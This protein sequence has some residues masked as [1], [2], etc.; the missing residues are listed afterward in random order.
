MS[1][2]AAMSIRNS[3][4]RVIRPTS[5]QL[6]ATNTS[7]RSI[8]RC[9]R[10]AHGDRA[11]RISRNFD[12]Y[13][14]YLLYHRRKPEIRHDSNPTPNDTHSSWSRT[15]W[16]SQS[17]S[18]NLLGE[19]ESRLWDSD[20]GQMHERIEFLRK[21]IEADPYRAV[22]G[23]RF[24]PFEKF[25]KFDKN[26]TLLESF[27]QSLPSMKRSPNVRP[28]IDKR[29]TKSEDN[30]VGLQYDPISGHMVPIT[31]FIAPKFSN[32]EPEI[33]SHKVVNYPPGNEVKAKFA[34]SPSLAED[35][36]LQPENK[37]LT[38]QAH[39]ISQPTVDCPPGSELDGLFT[40]TS[41]SQDAQ[42]RA[43]APQETERRPYVNIDYSPGSE[44]ETLFVSESIPSVQPQPDTFNLSGNT[45]KPNLDAGLT[46]G[47]NV[48]CSPGSELEAK[49]ISDPAS[50]SAN[51]YL[52]GLETQTP[53]KQI[54]ISIDCSPGNELD[55]RL[56]SEL[57][58]LSLESSDPVH[59]TTTTTAMMGTQESVEC[60][61]GSEIQ[62]EIQA[63]ILS[64]SISQNSTQ[65][66]A[67]TSFD[68]PPGSELEAIFVCSPASIEEKQLQPEVPAS[69]DTFKIANS[70]VDCT[71]GNEL[72]VKLISEMASTK[73]PNYNEDPG[74][75]DNRDIRFCYTPLESKLQ[76]NPLDFDA[77]KGRI[78]DFIPQS[79]NL[80]TE[81]EEQQ[82]PSQKSSPKFHIFALDVST[83]QVTTAQA[84]SFFGI[85][86]DSRPSEILSRLHNPAKFL[87]YF[88]KMQ[89]GGYK[90]ATGGGNILVFRKSQSTHHHPLSN[91]ATDQQL[92]IQAKIAKHLRHDPM[93]TA[94]IYAGTPWQ[95]TTEPPSEPS[96]PSSE[97]EPT[98][99][100][101]SSVR[102]AGRRILI[103]GTATVVTCYTIGVMTEFFRTG[104]KDGRGID[105]FTVFESDRRRE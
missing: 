81:K 53:N 35:G 100:S 27:L 58:S 37:G 14:R 23:R 22:F 30:H 50:R 71:P 17:S 6:V 69:L 31:S 34:Y 46:V 43:Q 12:K 28:R 25:D 78:G 79:Q 92:A 7:E 13:R 11:D 103:A 49:F 18:S 59:L 51:S 72:E 56:S 64:E 73:G 77:S 67:Q 89:E 82:V 87:P 52:S 55:A 3:G 45:N 83:S 85:D 8:W 75:L 101:E 29:Q 21:Y 26:D 36:Q 97:P 10:N 24:D 42:G 40:S 99:N 4:P 104:G 93:E 32:A 57:T 2:L 48:E 44:L 39:L 62:S 33:N 65:S 15:A 63:Q 38:P 20:S 96:S 61:P 94:A 98:T 95:P 66:G 68:C 70:V 16:L 102:K 60:S 90:I 1:Y 41:K 105:G 84:D 80:A 91:A 86:E 5:S 19:R 76:A 47:D 54:S 74:V 88:E 9:A